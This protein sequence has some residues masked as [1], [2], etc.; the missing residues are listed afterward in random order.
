M[1]DYTIR[2]LPQGV[3]TPALH[4]WKGPQD[5]L[6]NGWESLPK[7]PIAHFY[8]GGQPADVQAY[9]QVG[10][11]DAGLHV[12]LAA[13]EWP[14]VCRV[15][16]QGGPVYTDS[17]LEFFLQPFPMEDDR[18]LNVEMNAA[19]IM[20]IGL[21]TGR[22]ERF[23]CVQLPLCGMNAACSAAQSDAPWWAVA[24]TLPMTLFER[25]FGRRGLTPGQ[26]MRGNFYK[27]AEAPGHTHYGMFAPMP[28]KPD[29]HRPELFA[30][31][32][33]EP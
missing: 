30:S 10:Y 13:R 32:K 33:L 27:C 4:E 31:L 23:Q 5:P 3:G 16:E 9:A 28:G 8:P 21:G 1:C 24:Y 29:F 20:L 15:R 25:H 7:A 2:R 22:Q 26:V 6:P 17:C 18:Y 11:N 12:L 14:R 19:N